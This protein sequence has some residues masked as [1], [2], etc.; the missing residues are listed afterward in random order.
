MTGRR[1]ETLAWAMRVAGWSPERLAPRVNMALGPERRAR[2][3]TPSSA[4]KWRDRGAV[5]RDPLPAIIAGV[6]AEALG[7]PLSVDR[8]WQGRATVSDIWVPAD[9]GLDVPWNQAG[10]V[11][12]LNAVRGDR[13]LRREFLSIA[14]LPLLTP[15]L[16]WTKIEPGELVR[17]TRGGQVSTGLVAL[18]ESQISAIRRLDDSVGGEQILGITDSAFALVADLLRQSS[19]RSDLGRRLHVALAELAQLAGWASYDLGDHGQSQRHYL[20]ALH[21]A[22]TADDRPL[23]ARI[24]SC[25]AYQAA[26]RGYAQDA[27]TLADCAQRGLGDK[28]TPTVRS[29]LAAAEARAYAVAE[30]GRSFG[31]ALNRAEHELERARREDDPSWSYWHD[32]ANIAID[33]GSDF[34]RLGQFRA[35]ERRLREGFALRPDYVRDRAV[36]LPDLADIQRQQGD[37]DAACATASEA[38]RL[39]T[40]LGSARA[41]NGVRAFRAKLSRHTAARPVADF[42]TLTASLAS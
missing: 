41:L 9:F 10:T 5:P 30:D 18:I 33:S 38:Y 12:L 15:A 31:H 11:E 26:A 14:G 35:A 1:N 2:W 3:V 7:E 42:L 32:A 20:T 22:H 36:Y 4:Y 40:E 23:G 19:Y 34:G 16:E 8:L 21:A 27:I 13:V 24:L 25:L 6:L 17:A 28:A 37:L 29:L 39:G